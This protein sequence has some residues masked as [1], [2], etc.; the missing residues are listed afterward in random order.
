MK[1]RFFF[2]I[3]SA[4]AL[5]SCS[6]GN[7][8]TTPIKTDS[9]PSGQS[10]IFTVATAEKAFDAFNDACYD[11]SAKLYY[12][13]TDKK[14][15]GVV[16]AQAI[17][18]DIAINAYKQ[19][20]NPKYLTIVNDMYEGGGNY[21]GHYD[22]TNKTYWFIYDD[23]MWW[24]IALT[25]ASVLTS[26]QTYLQTAIA[27]F[28]QIW[29]GSYDPQ[30]GGMWW[31]FDHK[32]KNSCINFPTVIGAMK[33]FNATKDSSYFYKAKEIYAWGKTYLTD[34]TRGRVSDNKSV[35]GEVYYTDYTYNQGT[36]IGA[37]VMLYKATNVKG[38]LDDAIAAANYTKN[39]MS[40]GDGILPAEGDWNA[41]GVLKAI[42]GQYMYMLIYDANQTQYVPWMKNN[43]SLAWK[44]R[45]MTRN[46]M[47]RD[48]TIP[49]LSTMMQSY[50]ACSGVALM[51]LFNKEFGKTN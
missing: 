19:S 43:I 1:K 30:K 45:D 22:W 10:S 6:K 14:D 49:S 50:E 2:Y 28:D 38:Y 18:W 29:K 25:N 5:A 27:G 13:N 41:Q 7:S 35:N 24:V 33:L 16:W 44:N 11:K 48:Y 17:F 36:Y 4:V 8:D 3:L 46:L 12:E 42:F 51:Q 26:N 15:V 9:V 47:Y 23:M 34:S 37:A 39:V 21:Y 20:Q 31:D 32:S 40:D